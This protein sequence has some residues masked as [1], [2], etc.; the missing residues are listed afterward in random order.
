[1]NK[2]RWFRI[3]STDHLIKVDKVKIPKYVKDWIRLRS[4]AAQKFNG[5][6]LKIS[7]WID[8]NGIEADSSLYHGG[9]ESIVNP[10]AAAQELMSAIARHKLP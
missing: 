9:V 6:D 5:Y 8:K 1:M 3:G 7:E 2:I 4:A 10:E